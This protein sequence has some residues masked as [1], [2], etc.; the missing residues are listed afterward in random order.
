MTT[1]M[2]SITRGAGV[3][4]SAGRSLDLRGGIAGAG[5]VTGRA[6]GGVTHRRTSAV[7]RSSTR[8]CA[9]ANTA[10]PIAT[11]CAMVLTNA[12]QPGRSPSF[13]DSSKRASMASP[14]LSTTTS[15][16]D[17][18][19]GIACALRS[20]DGLLADS[21]TGDYEVSDDLAARQPKSN[22]GESRTTRMRERRSRAS[23]CENS[24]PVKPESS[25]LAAM[26]LSSR[27][28]GVLR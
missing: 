1:S 14:E 21:L 17:T 24:R 19:Q 13:F 12:P 6:M 10:A 7:A 4:A 23:S 2:R 26:P 3:A 27:I 15:R 11:V 16:I 18:R 22:R 9:V 5:A 8:T 25:Q 20:G 28:C